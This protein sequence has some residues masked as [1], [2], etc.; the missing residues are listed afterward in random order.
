M[1][2]QSFDPR[3]ATPFGPEI[4]DTDSAELDAIVLAAARAATTW[5][6][7][8]RAARAVAL[9]SVADRLDAAGDELIPLADHESGLGLPRLTGELA[10]TTF[11]LRMFAE[12]L[13]DPDYLPTRIDAADDRP[14]PAGHPEL[15]HVMVPLGPVAVYGASNFPFAFS[16]AG[17]DTASALAAGCPVVV[18]AHPSHPQLSTAVAAEVTAGLAAAGAP[19]GVFGLVH[20]M[21]AGAALITDPH[22]KAASFTGSFSGGRALA[23]LAAG[24]LEPIPFFGELGSVNPVFVTRS[25]AQRGSALAVE[26]LDSLTVGAGQ[27]CTNPGLLVIPRGELLEA[28]VTAA[29]GRAPGVFLNPGVAA[30]YAD[31]LRGLQS[32]PGASVAV[33]PDFAA[34]TGLSAPMALIS[35]DAADALAAIDALDVECFGPA[36]VIV[37]YDDDAQAL[38][39]A[40][41]L[42]GCLVAVVHGTVEEPVAAALVE[43]VARIAGRVAWNSWPTGVAVTPAQHHGGPFPSTTNS[44]HTSVGA[45]AAYRF[46]RPVAFQ[47]LPTALLPG[48]ALS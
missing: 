43:R 29:A 12:L 13:T 32:I 44:Q 39:L 17:G 19:S 36:G 21:G 38:A 18:K 40:E 1:S 6:A 33:A 45:A 22:I 10:R 16:V 31:R 26:Y 34:G 23:E 42:H 30:L 20:G 14:L 15:R 24:R 3:T 41:E 11:Q 2:T 48:V 4:A 46:V 37:E 47:S 9:R 8:P 35:L 27:F 25:A 7:T 28:I 5:A